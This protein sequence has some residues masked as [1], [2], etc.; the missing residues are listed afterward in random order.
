MICSDLRGPG[1]PFGESWVHTE[2]SWNCFAFQSTPAARNWSHFETH[3]KNCSLF[4]ASFFDVFVECSLFGFVVL[5]GARKLH[6][7]INFEVVLRVR[8]LIERSFAI[9]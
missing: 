6:V 1:A 9:V 4:A 8:D 2:D 7:G 5:L 3:S